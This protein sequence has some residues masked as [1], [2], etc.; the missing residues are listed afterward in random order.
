[1]KASFENTLIYGNT[2]IYG[3]DLEEAEIPITLQDYLH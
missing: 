1:M 3:L 2:W